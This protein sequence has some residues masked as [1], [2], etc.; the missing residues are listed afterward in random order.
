MGRRRFGLRG[1][2]PHRSA[3][4]PPPAGASSAWSSRPPS[5]LSSSCGSAVYEGLEVQHSSLPPG[6]RGLS[7]PPVRGWHEDASKEKGARGTHEPPRFQV[8]QEE[9]VREIRGEIEVDRRDDDEQPDCHRCPH[10]EDRPDPI[11][12]HRLIK[13]MIASA[14][15]P[16][17]SSRAL[18]A[19]ASETPAFSATSW[20]SSSGIAGP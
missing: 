19:S 9:S 3:D 16:P 5:P 11:D 10:A 17:H 6:F 1:Y 18:R 12:V 13:R 8:P 14:G 20:T 2:R 7:I 4:S 15:S